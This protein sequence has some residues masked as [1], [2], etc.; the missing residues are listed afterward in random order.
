[1]KP[2]TIEDLKFIKESLAYTKHNFENYTEYPSYEFKQQR[3][4]KVAE[5][6]AKVNELLKT[7]KQNK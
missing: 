1:M 5:V 3:L 2:L 6:A 4:N 7:V